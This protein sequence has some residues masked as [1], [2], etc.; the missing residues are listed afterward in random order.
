MVRRT[1][2]IPEHID[3]LIRQTAT[4]GE[5]FSAAV[6]RL[7]QQGIQ[8]GRPLPSWIGSATSTGDFPWDE[9]EHLDQIF[10]DPNFRH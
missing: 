10:G 8:N 2:S 1:I 7:V 5:S 3:T 4:E 9:E 6:A